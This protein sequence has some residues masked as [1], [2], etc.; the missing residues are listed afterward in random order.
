MT[1]EN[2]GNSEAQSPLAAQHEFLLAQ[3]GRGDSY[4][5]IAAALQRQGVQTSPAAVG[6]YCRKHL[7]AATG[8]KADGPPEALS[9]QAAWLGELDDLLETAG[10]DLRTLMDQ[11]LKLAG[12]AVERIEHCTAQLDSLAEALRERPAQSAR[13]IETE[14]R[15]P[16]DA[17]AQRIGELEAALRRL[18]GAAKSALLVAERR[19][20]LGAYL[21]GSVSGA[22]AGWL[23]FAQ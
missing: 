22:L 13:M 23:F 1:A 17:A 18:L 14:L 16:V 20:L 6:R 5:T 10:A 4:D 12:E 7:P 2:P 11:R 9:S 3:R 8:A 19:L 15:Q 21:L